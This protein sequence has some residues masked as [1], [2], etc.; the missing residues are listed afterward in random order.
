[1]AKR[2]GGGRGCEWPA[3]RQ[4]HPGGRVYRSA[5]RELEC[6]KSCW[7]LSGST[8]SVGSSPMRCTATAILPIVL[9]NLCT[10][11]PVAIHSSRS[12]SSRRWPRKGC[13]SSTRTR[14]PGFGIWRGS[15]R[16]AA[17]KLKRLS[18]ATQ[19]AIRQLACL[20][21]VAEIATLSLVH[22]ESEEEIQKALW[23]AARAGLILRLLR[24]PPRPCSGGSLCAHT[25]RQASGGTPSDWPSARVTDGAGE[26][27]GEDLR[28]CEPTRSRRRADRVARGT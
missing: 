21:N 28:D 5:R 20:G 15:A 23:E 27:R 17:G 2:L 26:N 8:M 25:R 19:N 18:G 4:P 3:H 1:V 16:R 9:R 7:H 24:I 11:R 22:G 13:S 10:R 12:S 6:R 14:Q